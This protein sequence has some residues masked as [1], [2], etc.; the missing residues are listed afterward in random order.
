M[1]EKLARANVRQ[2]CEI[3]SKDYKTGCHLLFENEFETHKPKLPLDRTPILACSF[4]F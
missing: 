4:W 2:I 3:T 1:P